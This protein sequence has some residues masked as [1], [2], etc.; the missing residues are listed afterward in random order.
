M[1][2]VI[3]GLV[4]I[5]IL[6]LLLFLEMHIGVA[7]GLVG[8]IG[9]MYLTSPQQ[10][11]SLLGMLA[12]SNMAS[13]DLTV[14]PLFIAMG[15]LA[16]S[17]GM[18]QELYDAA[19]KWVGSLRGGLAIATVAT[20]A[21]FSAVSGTSVGTAATISPIALPQ[22][23]K[24]GYDDSLATGS[25]AAGGTLGIL[26]P[27]STLLIFYGIL[28]ETSVG[29]LFIAG[30]LPGVLLSL[31][32]MLVIYI[33]T[34]RNAK[35]GP[36][37][38]KT[39]LKEKLGVLKNTWPTF[40]LFL[41]VIGG[42]YAGVFTATEAG[43]AGAFAALIIGIVRRRL[44]WRSLRT[45]LVET[46]R[47]T[48]MIVFMLIGAFIF[49]VFL[50]LSRLPVEISNI[51]SELDVN[52]YVILLG[53]VAIYVVCGCIMDMFAMLILTVPIF[54]PLMVTLGFDPVWF[55]VTVVIMMEQALITPP[56]GLNVFVIKGMA[57]DVP[58]SKIFVGIIP[59]WL[60]MVVCVIL[61]T[62]FPQIA[63]FLGSP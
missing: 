31:L 16:S 7:M 21:G 41:V 49:N 35:L 19:Y 1:N 44:G 28:T 11:F 17:S 2:P 58:I 26:I 55:G 32:F 62:V 34:K 56:V 24:Y 14:L 6:L 46:M 3:V 13:Y 52:P 38:P 54:F 5:G 37:G 48:A 10:G 9:F 51:L 23:K 4:G 30:I 60:A 59:F 63:L 29:A 15:M 20:C 61:L 42:L 12:Y 45:A 36:P 27:P 33:V 40:A 47:T 39:T 18:A 43:G 8:L 57:K 22:M 25:V 53:I 50:A